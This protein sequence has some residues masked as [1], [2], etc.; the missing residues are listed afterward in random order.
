MNLTVKSILVGGL[1]MLLFTIL[2]AL[3]LPH[4]FC[5]MLVV[6]GGIVPVF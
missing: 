3:L 2:P 1:F 5:C 6:V 4:P